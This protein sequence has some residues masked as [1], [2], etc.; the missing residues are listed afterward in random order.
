M[1]PSAGSPSN[2]TPGRNRYWVIVFVFW[3]LLILFLTLEPQA[4]EAPDDASHWCVICGARGVSDALSNL[5]L[6]LPLGAALA[7]GRGLASA[8]V[9]SALIS[10]LIE[11]I[12]LWIPG[13]FSNLGDV[14]FNT[15]GGLLGAYIVRKIPALLQG[16][17]ASSVRVRLTLLC[18]P[19]TVLLITTGLLSPHLPGGE[20][21][22]QWTRGLGELEPYDGRVLWARIGESPLPDGLIPDQ[23]QVKRAFRGGEE[24]RVEVL[25]GSPAREPAPL[26]AVFDHREWEVFLLWVL[27]DDLHFQPGTLSGILGFDQPDLTVPGAFALDRGDSLTVTISM[28]PTRLCVGSPTGEVCDE[29][30][31][32]E[33]GWQLLFSFTGLPPWARGVLGGVWLA[34]LCIPM[35]LATPS[36]R[37]C[38][39]LALSAAS[40][41]VGASWVLPHLM[42]TLV[43]A[44][45]PVLG[46]VGGSL[47]GAHLRAPGR[48]FDASQKPG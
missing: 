6:F 37:K 39:L 18:A 41:A 27:G 22:A 20:Y 30:G 32:V 28:Q 12:Q 15:A 44:F 19:P 5:G 45:S 7:F 48:T 10:G 26:F 36:A 33:S 35:G 42:P 21:F 43:T 47:F 9:G 16:I 2:S 4:G 13:R 3:L 17:R 8:W 24:I 31:G 29:V 14:V 25:V 1:A 34:S 40:A 11:V 23:S 38:V 46:V